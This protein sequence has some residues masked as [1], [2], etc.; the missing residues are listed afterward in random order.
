MLNQ[1]STFTMSDFGRTLTSNGNGT[2]HGWGGVQMVMGGAA[3]NGGSLQGRRIWGDYPLLELDGDQSM[4]RGRMIPTTSIQQ[5][6]ATMATWLGVPD[7]DLATI[8]P[9]LG[10]FAAPRLGLLG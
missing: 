8:F 3:A 7:G 4:G 1:V 2:D 6:G 5:Y 10:N 9:G